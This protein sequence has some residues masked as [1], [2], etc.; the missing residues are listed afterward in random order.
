[1]KSRLMELL[2]RQRNLV[3]LLV[4]G[5]L[6]PL[7]TNLASSW[8]EM[9]I[10]R[11]PNRLMQLLAIGVALIVGLWVLHMAL[12]RQ[13]PLELVPEEERPSRYPGLIVLVGIGRKDTKPE[14]LSHNLAIEYHL[15]CEE[16]GGDALRVCWLIATGGVKGSVPVA[17]EVRKRYESHCDKVI[18][19]VLNSAFDVQEAYRLVRGIYTEEAAEYGLAPE[20]IIADFTGG[21]KPMSAGMILACQDRWPMQYMF[22]REGEVASTPLLVRF[23]SAEA[24]SEVA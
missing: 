21:T 10:G 8:L 2:R 1:M 5:L 16:A 15:S 9:T 3:L 12:G 4:S 17:R 22:G 24:E 6:V 19:H 7:F 14:E 11:T 18:L 23:Q 20:Q 13:E